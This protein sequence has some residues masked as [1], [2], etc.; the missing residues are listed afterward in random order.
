MWTIKK[1]WA[2]DFMSFNL[3]D[4]EYAKG[5]AVVQ[6]ENLTDPGQV[7][8]GGGKSSFIDIVPIALLGQ[9]ITGRNLKDC[10]N[11]ASDEKFF[12][13]GVLLSH[14]DGRECEIIRKVYNNTKA[15]ELQ[16]LI[17]GETPKTIPTK[18]NV[19]GAVDVK[20]GNRYILDEI[21]CL[22]KEDLLS[23]YLIASG[24]Y[25]PYMKMSANKRTEVVSKI[26][27]VDLIDKA[28]YQVEV[29]NTHTA[30]R[31]RA[32]SLI[33]S[34]TDT[35]THQQEVLEEKRTNMP[36]GESLIHHQDAISDARDL[37]QEILDRVIDTSTLEE[38]RVLRKEVHEELVTLEANKRSNDQLVAT[39]E[40]YLIGV[41]KCPACQ[42]EFLPND[43]QNVDQVRDDLVLATSEFQIAEDAVNLQH[44]T[45][46][47]VDELGKE[48]GVEVS[49]LEE[50]K[51]ADI[52]AIRSEI[53]TLETDLKKQELAQQ[54]LDQMET[55]IKVNQNKIIEYE[56]KVIEALKGEELSSEW[57]KT[58]NDF[59]FHMANKPVKAIAGHINHYLEKN[60]SDLRVEIEGFKKLKSGEIRQQLTPR[61]FRMGEERDYASFSG[62]ERARI[63]L[64]CDLAF[65]E[66]MNASSL[67]GGLNYYQN[68][69]LLNPVD[70]EGIAN[71]ARAF[72]ELDKTI[73]LVSHSGSELSYEKVVMLRKENGITE[74][75]TNN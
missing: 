67:S 3:M 62:G 40:K 68:D 65:Q 2:G 51:R 12:Q 39:L 35:I 72:D 55:T 24:Y 27:R 46:V 17:D 54:E 50:E 11:W 13:V 71:A 70:V 38:L 66:I 34:T 45:L 14:T 60:K 42:H 59:K 26:S 69:E 20:E 1:Q 56:K 15:Q 73:L 47:E 9:S 4:Y 25:T 41:I 63:D 7:S 75:I 8:N 19:E 16:I 36:D 5:C 48:A 21:L 33:V 57:I 10:I 43:D 74:C 32:E 58:L 22:A 30:D 6:A 61:I 64:S 52:Q 53:L 44:E 31:E 29:D 37:L 23:Y 28:I 49:R 18:S